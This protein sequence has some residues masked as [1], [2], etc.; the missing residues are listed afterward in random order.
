[1]VYYIPL[2]SLCFY[3]RSVQP[4]VLVA[5]QLK[6]LN[7]CGL[8]FKRMIQAPSQNLSNLGVGKTA[9]VVQKLSASAGG[10]SWYLALASAFQQL[11]VKCTFHPSW[12]L[13][14]NY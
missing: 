12:L 6:P 8:H 11:L 2:G 1:M 14:T 13:P 10:E 9:Y 7:A 5:D 3:L 4:S